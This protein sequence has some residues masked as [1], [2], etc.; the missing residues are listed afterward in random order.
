M[1]WGPEAVHTCGSEFEF[2][3]GVTQTFVHLISVSLGILLC[4]M[5]RERLPASDAGRMQRTQA[6]S[7]VHS[8]NGSYI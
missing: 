5:G 6:S 8:V 4:Q 3:L 7:P 2:L 1:G